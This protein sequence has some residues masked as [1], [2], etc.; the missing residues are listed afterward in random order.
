MRDR[1][2]GAAL[3]ETFERE[4][5][6]LFRFGIERGSRFIEEQDRR[7]FQQRAGDRETLL[8]SAG[9]QAALVADDRFVALAV[10]P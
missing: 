8:L 4:L 5:N 6:L 7:V 3:G 2:D 9:K 1:D 10:A